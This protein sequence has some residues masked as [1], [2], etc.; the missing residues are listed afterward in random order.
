MDFSLS[1][2][3]LALKRMC[4]DLVARHVLEQA[5]GWS[6]RHESPTDVYRTMGEVGLMGM[7]VE[8]QY[9]GAGATYVDYVAA[10]EEI[11]AG[12][13]SLAAG[14]N[15]HSTIA[16]LPLA[17]FGT[18]AQKERW[19]RPL[20]EGRA[21]GAFALTEP[22]AGSDAAAIRTRARKVDGGW[23]LDGTKMFISNAGTSMSLGA[24]VLAV[25]R[26]A[27]ENS[28]RRYAVFFV[29]EGTPGY[30]KGQRL[31]KLGWAALDTRELVFERCF[32]PD[33]HLIG[34]EGGGLRQFLSVLDPGR[35]SVAALGLSLAQ[36]ALDMAVTH[37]RQRHQFGRPLVEFQAVAHKLADMATEVEAARA[38][39]YRAAWLADAGESFGQAAA[40]AKLYSSEVATRVASESLQIH[41]GYGYMRES[42]ISRFYS[43]AKI[44][45]IGE[46]TS[47]IQRNVI[48]R[49]LVSGSPRAT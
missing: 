20:A 47:E 44:L 6:E 3:T 45:E 43:D 37:A 23:V 30:G 14:W 12:D 21:L 39:V 25:T 35:I 5:A 11:G 28:P 48:A 42:R 1:Q 33:D 10:M 36:A 22:T 49:T 16:T 34:D 29:P 27:T 2:E 9:G 7:L 18:D 8:E 31:D 13:Q 24:S 41:G 32:V 17:R 40:M 15:A 4:R 38:L 26:E 19:L 46:G